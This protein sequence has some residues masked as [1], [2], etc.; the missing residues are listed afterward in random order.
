M[1]SLRW[2]KTNL[3][4]WLTLRELNDLRFMRIPVFISLFITPFLFLLFLLCLVTSGD[5]GDVCVC[6][7]LSVY[8]P[9]VL[10]PPSHSSFSSC[11]V[12]W[13]HHCQG[14]PGQEV[15]GY[16]VLSSHTVTQSL[17]IHSYQFFC[18]WEVQGAGA[19]IDCT[20]FRR[21]SVFSLSEWGNLPSSQWIDLQSMNI[22]LPSLVT[23]LLFEI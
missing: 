5:A 11:N 9:R 22:N 8:R 10:P 16:L 19:S 15:T 3:D 1:F 20:A 23:W 14:R 21:W 12:L 6:W 13:S 4:C 7:C 2:D 17:P 18:E